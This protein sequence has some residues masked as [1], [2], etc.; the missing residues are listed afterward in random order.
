MCRDFDLQTEDCEHYIVYFQE[1]IE[2]HTLYC[3]CF[4]RNIA[5]SFHP[6]GD[7]YYFH[8]LKE[9]NSFSVID[10][11]YWE[12]QRKSQRQLQKKIAELVGDQYPHLYSVLLIEEKAKLTYFCLTVLRKTTQ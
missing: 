2:I 11:K 1:D 7:E 9:E 12:K 3:N 4:E 10:W 8:C 6:N 5:V